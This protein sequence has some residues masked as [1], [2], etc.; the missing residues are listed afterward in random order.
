MTGIPAMLL[1]VNKT[2]ALIIFLGVFIVIG[3]LIGAYFMFRYCRL[4]LKDMAGSQEFM[5]GTSEEDN[6]K[7][8]DSTLS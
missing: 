8:S 4:R 5:S 6:S 2:R 1:A 7:S 3:L